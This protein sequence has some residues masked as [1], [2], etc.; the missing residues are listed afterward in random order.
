MACITITEG[1]RDAARDVRMEKVASTAARKEPKRSRTRRSMRPARITAIRE[2]STSLAQA[3]F[4]EPQLRLIRDVDVDRDA[5]V[6]RAALGSRIVSDGLRRAR[7]F[8]EHL[9]RPDASACQDVPCR[10]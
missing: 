6:L 8:H 7:P 5:A 2:T 10:F 9:L 3:G 4:G 1:P